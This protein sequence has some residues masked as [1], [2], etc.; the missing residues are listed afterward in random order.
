ML[1]SVAAFLELW[2]NPVEFV[3]IR[4]IPNPTHF[5]ATVVIEAPNNPPLA[6]QMH[7]MRLG[8]A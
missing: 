3:E 4:G 5:L 6:I 2:D 1:P 8:V 7:P